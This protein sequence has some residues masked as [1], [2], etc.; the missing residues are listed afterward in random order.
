[1]FDGM[2]GGNRVLA[3]IDTRPRGKTVGASSRGRRNCHAFDEIESLKEDD[4]TA[5]YDGNEDANLEHPQPAWLSTFVPKS[6]A[7]NAAAAL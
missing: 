5:E 2:L 4:A 3:I 6:L 7:A 1:M